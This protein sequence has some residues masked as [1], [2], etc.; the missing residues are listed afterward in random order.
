MVIHLSLMENYQKKSDPLFRMLLL[1]LL[2]GSQ[3]KGLTGGILK[4]QI[5][6]FLV[7]LSELLL[8]GS[9]HLYAQ[10]RLDSRWSD[11]LHA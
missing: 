10:M 9:F 7:R 11:V 1:L 5:Q 8:D 6:T 4:D 2:G 3:S